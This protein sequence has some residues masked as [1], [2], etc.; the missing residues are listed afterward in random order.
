[1]AYRIGTAVD[2]ADFLNQI[3]DFLTTR[4]EY[5]T[6][7][8]SGTG[9]GLLSAYTAV[10]AAPT[11]DWVLTCTVGGP[12]GTFSVSGSLS[13]VLADATSGTP[14]SNAIISFT[15]TDGATAWIA[16]DTITFNVVS[17]MGV[18]KPYRII[19]KTITTRTIRQSNDGSQFI[20]WQFEQHTLVPGKFPE[21]KG[22]NVTGTLMLNNNPAMTDDTI[23]DAAWDSGLGVYS[24]SLWSQHTTSLWY[25]YYSNTCYELGGVSMLWVSPHGTVSTGRTGCS[26]ASGYNMVKASVNTNWDYAAG[27]YDIGEYTPS[28]ARML[29][30]KWQL[31]TLTVSATT[32][33]MYIDDTPV[34]TLPVDATDKTKAFISRL[35]G[36]SQDMVD[37]RQN[38]YPAGLDYFKTGLNTQ[39]FFGAISDFCVWNKELS[40]AEVTALLGS[41]AA[42]DAGHVD[43]LWKLQFVDEITKNLVIQN[44][45]T[46]GFSSIFRIGYDEAHSID[47]AVAQVNPSLGVEVF[48]HPYMYT[49]GASTTGMDVTKRCGDNTTSTNNFGDEFI[50]RDA[51]RIYGALRGIVGAIE[52]YWIVADEDRIIISYKIHDTGATVQKDPVYQTLYFGLLEQTGQNVQNLAAFGTSLTPVDWQSASSSFTNGLQSNL[53]G[54]VFAGTGMWQRH[55]SDIGGGNE[56]TIRSINAAHYLWPINYYKEQNLVNSELLK[57]EMAWA[58][59]TLYQH[60]FSDLQFGS[61][62]GLYKVS[63]LNVIAEDIITVNSENFVVLSNCAHTGAGDWFALQL[64]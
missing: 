56:G 58:S 1:M 43:L 34:F 20:P 57:D 24:I 38:N 11:E 27:G 49:T 59:G 8:V 40:Q 4:N 5:Q 32:Y 12:A 31:F 53:S 17:N 33:T 42:V 3:E 46:R 13:G 39:G 16:G 54:R 60:Q 15:I 10:D 62:K 61:P 29:S 52:K 55:W 50:S 7:L 18:T 41:T 25:Q 22:L 63:P 36:S 14:Y 48:P 19:D 6:I 45:S 30:G 9:D 37:D 44:D 21:E 64:K 47:C 28:V 26:W 2:S 23:T 35:F 51:K